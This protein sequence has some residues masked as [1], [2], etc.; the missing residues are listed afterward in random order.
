[1][2]TYN[3]ARFLREQLD[4]LV[5]QSRLPNE[6]VATDDGST[7]ATVAILTEF[8]ASAPFSVRIHRNPSRLGYRANFMQ[9]MAL[10]QSDIIALCDQDDVWEAEKLEVAVQAFADPAVELF[11][12]NAWLIDRIG[13]MIGPA[14]ILVLPA[15]STPL[16]FYPLTNPFGFSIVFRRRLMRF[17]EHWHASVD[18]IEAANRMA[19]DQWIFFLASV[20]GV[21][22]YTDAKLVR[23]RQHGDNA[24]GWNRLTGVGRRLSALLRDNSADHRQFSLAAAGR[25]RILREILATPLSPPQREQAEACTTY[26][27]SLHLR[28]ALR[29]D[30]YRASHAH[31]R[32]LACL[33]LLRAG[34]YDRGRLWN[35]GPKAILKDIVLGL[36][37]RPLMVRRADHDSRAADLRRDI[38]T[39][40]S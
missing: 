31:R 39:I 21:I 11:F 37:F 20:F 26:Y 2:A 32:A 25:A 28:L 33:R 29:A 16:S 5:A 17:A 22:V 30:I 34:G 35:I 19:H 18:T 3:G 4:S 6:L 15:R 40:P 1:M 10:C 9:A 8:A 7:D 14:D 23:Y 12:H 27:E 13:G 36:I 38:K 24:Y